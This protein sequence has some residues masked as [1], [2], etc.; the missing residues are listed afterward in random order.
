[1][2]RNRERV[3]LW[4]CSDFLLQRLMGAGTRMMSVDL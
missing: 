1:M 4:M 3:P 2:L